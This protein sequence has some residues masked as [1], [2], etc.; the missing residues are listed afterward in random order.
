MKKYL[1]LAVLAIV[2][3][4]GCRTTYQTLSAGK[5]NVSFVLVTTDNPD[6][7]KNISI[8]IDNEQPILME[9]VFK[10]KKQLQAKPITT[11]PGRHAIKVLQGERVLYQQIVLI[12]LQETKKI[13]L[14]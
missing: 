9:K 2:S 6:Y 4:V 10:T 13:V 8:V 3:L 14:P 1:L 12:G 5:E 7:R 11:T